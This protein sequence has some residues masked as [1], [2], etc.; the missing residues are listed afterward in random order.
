MPKVVRSRKCVTSCP[1]PGPMLPSGR[2]SFKEVSLTRCPRRQPWRVGLTPHPQPVPKTLIRDQNCIFHRALV[3]VFVCV[4]VC[5][6]VCVYIYL[7]GEGWG[8]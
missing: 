2:I 7:V 8:V 1:T 4:C 6:C 3:C 5:V